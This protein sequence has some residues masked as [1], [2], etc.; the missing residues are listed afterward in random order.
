MIPI[1]DKWDL[2]YNK[3]LTNFLLICSIIIILI[4]SEYIL[5]FEKLINI[6]YKL[7]CFKSFIK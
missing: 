4:Y 6:E 1:G 3:T 7:Y 2:F 5:Q